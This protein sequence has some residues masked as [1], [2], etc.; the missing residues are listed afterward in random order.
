MSS[1]GP[2]NATIVLDA[3]VPTVTGGRGLLHR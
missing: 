2:I 1:S 3:S